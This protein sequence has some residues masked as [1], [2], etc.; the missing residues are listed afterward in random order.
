MKYRVRFI[1]LQTKRIIYL[2]P[3]LNY[4][5]AINM[6]TIYL[7]LFFF[8][9]CLF[10]YNFQTHCASRPTVLRGRRDVP[11]I[12]FL[13]KPIHNII[14]GIFRVENA[15]S[16][17]ASENLRNLITLS[18]ATFVWIGGW[19]KKTGTIITE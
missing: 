15:T 4:L 16:T 12:Q 10:V 9:M 8:N 5:V 11:Y 6:R 7:C 17:T 14:D 1:L 19:G 13:P 18:A 3:E 2:L